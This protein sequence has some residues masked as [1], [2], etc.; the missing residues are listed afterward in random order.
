MDYTIEDEHAPTVTTSQVGLIL[1]GLTHGDVL[2]LI[3]TTDIPHETVDGELCFD[4]E[5]LKDWIY[6]NTIP[7][8]GPPLSPE[9]IV[10]LNLGS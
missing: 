4:L 10:V 5:E 6:R 7:V 9:E 2:E 8:S 3:D 1:G